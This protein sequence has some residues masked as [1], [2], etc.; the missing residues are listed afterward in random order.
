MIDNALGKKIEIP[1]TGTHACICEIIISETAGMIKDISVPNSE[2]HSGEQISLDYQIGEKI[3]KFKT[4][5]DRVGQ[6]VVRAVDTSRAFD[7]L[8]KLKKK[9]HIVVQ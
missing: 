9:T 6:L 8:T 7:R 1:N 5:T 4:G 2:L 3:P